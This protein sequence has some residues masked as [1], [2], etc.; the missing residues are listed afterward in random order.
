[1]KKT[2]PTKQESKATNR[3][4]NKKVTKDQE[5]LYTISALNSY[6]KY[7]NNKGLKE[8]SNLSEIWMF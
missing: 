8:I 1:M 5:T 6:K 7:S 4:G 2:Q 3:E